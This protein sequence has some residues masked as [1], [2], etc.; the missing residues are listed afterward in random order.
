LP[1]IVLAL[2]ALIGESILL[3]QRAVR[4]RPAHV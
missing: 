1:L 3:A 4:W 2:L